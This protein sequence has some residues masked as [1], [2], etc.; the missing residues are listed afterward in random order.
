MKI[1]SVTP[2]TRGD[3]QYFRTVNYLKHLEVVAWIKIQKPNLH[4]IGLFV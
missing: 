2:V 4:Q 3:I 1:A